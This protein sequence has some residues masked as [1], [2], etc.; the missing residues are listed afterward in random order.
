MKLKLEERV[1][2]VLHRLGWKR[3]PPNFIGQHKDF[4][5]L[6]NKVKSRALLGIERAFFFVSVFKTGFNFTRR[7][8]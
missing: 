7:C 2:D 6:F 8:S 5:D 4:I 1:Y 3:K